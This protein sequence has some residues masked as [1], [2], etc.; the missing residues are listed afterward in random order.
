MRL[1][2]FG[3]GV[4]NIRFCMQL[5]PFYDIALTLSV[6]PNLSKTFTD[7]TKQKLMST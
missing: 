6:L 5:K 4:K 2:K 7:V 1:E 3:V